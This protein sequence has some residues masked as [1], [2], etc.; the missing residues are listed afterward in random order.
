MEMNTGSIISIIIA[1]ILIAYL[2]PAAIESFYTAN[3]SAW[4]FGGVEDTKT[5]NIWMLMPLICV[6]VFLAAIAKHAGLF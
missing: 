4:A 3:T 1:V 5:I 6:V 2:A